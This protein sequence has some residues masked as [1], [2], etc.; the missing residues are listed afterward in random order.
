MVI[1][2]QNQQAK[3][4]RAGIGSVAQ[5]GG[6]FL[7]RIN[8]LILATILSGLPEMEAEG[9]QDQSSYPAESRATQL[10]AHRRRAPAVSKCSENSCPLSVEV[11]R[12]QRLHVSEKSFLKHGFNGGLNRSILFI[13][14][15]PIQRFPGESA[16]RTRRSRGP[17]EATGEDDAQPLKNVFA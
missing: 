15:G 1:T 13:S 7:T 17:S 12:S 10:R 8:A 5:L 2:L 11:S 3:D 4:F 6:I 9:E 14:P 16:T